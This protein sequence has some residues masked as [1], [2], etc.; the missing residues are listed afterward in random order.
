ML[1]TEW[2]AKLKILLPNFLHK[3]F[4]DPCYGKITKILSVM[5]SYSFRAGNNI[6]L[7]HHFIENKTGPSMQESTF[8]E[9]LCA[10][11]CA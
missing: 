8:I 11:H 7:E 6:G 2:C 3:T 10:K 9:C 4:A 1:K 5:E